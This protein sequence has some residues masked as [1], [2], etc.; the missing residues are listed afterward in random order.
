MI[1][2]AMKGSIAAGHTET[3][4]AGAQVLRRGGNAVDATIASTLSAFIAEPGLTSPFGGGFA[5]VAGPGIEPVAIDFFADIPGRDCNAAE[6]HTTDFFS[7]QVSFGVTEQVF[8]IGRGSL[9]VSSVLEGLAE[10]ERRFGSLPL[11]A[12]ADRAVEMA[13]QGVVLSSATADILRILEPILMH[14]SEGRRIFAPR[15][16][17]LTAGERL[18][19]PQAAHLLRDFSH[20]ASSLPSDP[21]LRGFSPPNGLVTLADLHAYRAVS[22]HPLSVTV[23]DFEVLLTPP[24]ASGGVLIALGLR[25]LERVDRSVWCN[26]IRSAQCFAAALAWLDEV[27]RMSVDPLLEAGDGDAINEVLA[28]PQF[29]D[30][31][32]SRF[33]ELLLNPL[34]S[35]ITPPRSLG[36]TT[37]I[38]VIDSQGMACALTSSNGEGCGYVVPGTGIIGNNFLGEADL[39][40][41]GFHQ[42]PAGQ[43]MTSMMCP[44]I[45]LQRGVPTLALGSGGSN[46][47]RSALL[48]V[49]VEYLFRDRGLDEAVASP[50]MHFEAGGLAFEAHQRSP[51]TVA[52]LT[53]HYPDAVVFSEPNLFFGGVNVAARDRLGASDPRRQGCALVVAH[54]EPGEAP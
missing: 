14:R 41:R 17:M 52:K 50:R 13:E 53:E 32:W 9:A 25:L 21:F 40:P 38:S 44:T 28:D 19:N 30:R 2:N 36:S 39:H 10:L 37:H 3:A 27:R 46:R 45:V 20:G 48:H 22:R 7:V 51:G 26:D 33:C 31:R 6:S 29:V 8:H 54:N 5:L 1:R 15:G 34:R 42:D 43:R 49:L 24:P 35:P 4:E 47:I 23:E 18:L 11:T 12:L 16:A